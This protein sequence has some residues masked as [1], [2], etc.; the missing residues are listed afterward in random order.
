MLGIPSRRI[1]LFAV[2]RHELIPRP[3]VAIKITS[4]KDSWTDYALTGV[5][6]KRDSPE[7]VDRAVAFSKPKKLLQLSVWPPRSRL[8]RGLF[9]A[10]VACTSG[11][12]EHLQGV[13]WCMTITLAA[14]T[15]A[16]FK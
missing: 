8:G 4:L 9:V 3:G 10:V 5:W 7:V 14:S 6:T 11:P 2:L 15:K 12:R 16:H 13:F 1:H